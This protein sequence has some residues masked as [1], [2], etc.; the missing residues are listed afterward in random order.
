M[1]KKP[2]QRRLAEQLLTK[3]RLIPPLLLSYILV[4]HVDQ[5]L[6]FR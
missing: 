2:T 3:M 6:L 4:P 5:R 1:Y